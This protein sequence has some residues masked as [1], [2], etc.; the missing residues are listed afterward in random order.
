VSARQVI[1]PIGRQNRVQLPAVAA[2][3]ATRLKALAAVRVAIKDNNRI[4]K[5]EVMVASS[6]SGSVTCSLSRI[7]LFWFHPLFIRIEL[8][9]IRCS[10]LSQTLICLI[11][12]FTP[13]VSA[14]RTCQAC[15]A[16]AGLTPNTRTI[17]SPVEHCHT[18]KPA[19]LCRDPS[20]GN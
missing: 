14:P 3:V 18:T 15:V 19:P 4:F 17:R 11:G 7:P 8:L 12:F 13:R 20:A 6:G 9:D 2:L 16:S 5:C 10:S 1:S